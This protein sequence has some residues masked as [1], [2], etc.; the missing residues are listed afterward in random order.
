VSGVRRTALVTG[1]TSGI[2]LEFARALAADHDLVL[3]AR[4]Q[5]GLDAVDDELA[6]RTAVD[7]VAA[8]LTDDA[9]VDAVAALFARRRIDLL[10]NNAGFG[11][12]GGFTE[13]TL[14]SQTDMVRCNVLA[15]VALSHAA[16]EPMRARGD[17]A[18]LN[19]ASTA[20]YQPMPWTATYGAT[21]SFVTN[22][23]QA[24]AEELAG[25]GVRAMALCPGYT[26]TGFQ[27][28]AGVDE[29]NLPGFLFTS[30][31]DVVATALADLARGRSVSIPGGVNRAIAAASKASPGT[32]SRKLSA[33]MTKRSAAP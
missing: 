24:L 2:G 15:V 27:D 32:V 13:A 6:D 29:A 8:D 25:T 7:T 17:G 3:V 22:F 18:V 9:G 33:A 30:A 28:R 23:T 26:P 31:A 14:R 12:V 21:K 1:A 16:L 20:G 10:V 4:G 5:A 19:V 11:T